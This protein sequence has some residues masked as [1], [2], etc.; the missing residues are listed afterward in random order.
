MKYNLKKYIRFLREPYKRKT[1]LFF[2][3]KPQLIYSK[4]TLANPVVSKNT[5]NEILHIKTLNINQVSWDA[6]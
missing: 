5:F 4:I 1:L 3:N 2:F 6:I